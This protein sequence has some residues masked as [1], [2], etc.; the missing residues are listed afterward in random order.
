MLLCVTRPATDGLCVAVSRSAVAHPRSNVAMS[1]PVSSHRRLACRRWH[2][3]LLSCATLSL[4]SCAEIIAPQ[5]LR[6]EGRPDGLEFALGGFG[7]A[8]S[9]V[10][11]RSDTIVAWRRA[12]DGQPG[13]PVDS[14]KTVPT[15]EEWRTF[16]D[17]AERA[18]VHR[19]HSRYV[20]EG[21]VD[22][23]GWSLRIVAGGRVLQSMGSNAYPDRLGGE[24]R[25]E[26]TEDFQLFLSALS[27]MTRA[28][29]G[30]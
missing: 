13:A 2:F 22:G 1:G 30:F 28:R 20:A 9:T 6:V 14:V 21:V 29:V 23:S 4:A 7:A 12:F 19:W 26:V 11:L 24:H 5:P 15:A 10:S 27:T 8:T 17:A 18:G 3:S 16:W 25:L